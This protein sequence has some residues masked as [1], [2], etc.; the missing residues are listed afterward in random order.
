MELTEKKHLPVCP[1]AA[2]GIRK[3]R[4]AIAKYFELQANPKRIFI[5]PKVKSYLKIFHK[6]E[7]ER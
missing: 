6:I 1:K 5:S 4:M 7:L 2:L 3:T